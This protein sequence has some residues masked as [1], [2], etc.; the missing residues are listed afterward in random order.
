MLSTKRPVI[1]TN[2]CALLVTVSY[3]S[4]GVYFV[5]LLYFVMLHCV[6]LCCVLLCRGF[7]CIVVLC[8]V[9]LV[10]LCC[11]VVLNSVVFYCCCDMLC[12]VSLGCAVLCCVVSWVVVLYCELGCAVLCCINTY[13]LAQRLFES[14][15]I[16]AREISWCGNLVHFIQSLTGFHCMVLNG[17]VLSLIGKVNSFFNT[18]TA[19]WTP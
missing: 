9:V 18:G 3:N 6:A 19:F 12:C 4:G 8:C 16:K 2:I 15:I 13:Q 11:C 14:F 1:S 7:S 5:V 17:C 10:V